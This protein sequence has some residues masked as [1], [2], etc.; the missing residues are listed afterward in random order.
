MSSLSNAVERLIASQTVLWETARR[1]YAAL[2]GIASRNIDFGD[3]SMAVQFNPERARSTTASPEIV[4]TRP[5]FLCAA[6]RPAEQE[7]I[8]WKGYEI[9]VNP[10]P[11]FSPHLTVPATAH[12]PQFLAGRFNDMVR[13]SE[14]LSGFVLTF[15]GARCGA[16]APDH[17]H[18][19]AVGQGILP[20][21]REVAAA[22]GR[23]ALCDATDVSVWA[24]DR[25]LRPK[26][27]VEG[28]SADETARTAE[29]V[30]ACLT[31]AASDPVEAQVN[32]L[33]WTA[34]DKHTVV[35]FPRTAHRPQ[36][37]HASN[38][39]QFLFS[40]GAMDMAGVVVTVRE[41]DYRRASA[42]LLADLFAQV[43]PN[44][45]QWQQIKSEIRL[46]LARNRK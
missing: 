32:A 40:P 45:T 36:Q 35:F 9:L 43:V 3:F 7:S 34:P 22:T 39:T 6:H 25:F 46:C 14:E 37:Y 20:V 19:Q 1:N 10:Y 38:E 2:S 18:F 29:S 26:I 33:A 28:R 21:Q 12:T 31:K 5:C 41:R 4:S 24:S 30:L 27:V 23:D 8:R 17:F 13:L 15:N 42:S 16:S 44:H 11:I